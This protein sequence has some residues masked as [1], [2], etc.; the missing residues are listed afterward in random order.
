MAGIGPKGAG[1]LIQKFGSL[2]YLYGHLEELDIKPAMKAKLEKSRDNAFLSYDLGTI[3]RDA[4][5]DTDP[6][7]YRRSKGDP[8]AAAKLLAELEMHKL[9][10]RWGLNE[11]ESA[12]PVQTDL[13]KVI[14]SPLPL[15][16]EGRYYLAR[17][18]G[19]EGGE[20]YAVQGSEVFALDESR[21]PGLLDGGA[22]LFV[23]DAKPLYRLALEHGGVGAAIRFDGNWRRIC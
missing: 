12:G 9:A 16:T 5:I 11:S 20:W 2:Q 3:R 17:T 15:V 19:K 14:P 8:A 23:F 21:L 1:E 13:P 10:A 4:P 6:E 18:A 22:E 7:H